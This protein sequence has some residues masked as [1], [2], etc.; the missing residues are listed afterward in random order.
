[1]ISAK[2]Y[3]TQYVLDYDSCKCCETDRE[4][5]KKDAKKI[6]EKILNDNDD[7]MWS[8][9]DFHIDRYIDCYLEGK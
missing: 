1:M 7:H 5:T 8:D 6:A 4:I 9:I 3:W 2:K